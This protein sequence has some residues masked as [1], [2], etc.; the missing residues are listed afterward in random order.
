LPWFNLQDRSGSG[1][2]VKERIG[3][4]AGGPRLDRWTLLDG[5]FNSGESASIVFLLQKASLTP[6]EGK[7]PCFRKQ[8]P[9]AALR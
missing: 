7:S 9:A 6:S 5:T 4:F 8:V 1:L 3:V 2:T